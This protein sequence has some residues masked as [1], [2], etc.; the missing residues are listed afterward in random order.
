[1]RTAASVNEPETAIDQCRQQSASQPLFP[2][3]S[4]V[5]TRACHLLT[6]GEGKVRPGYGSVRPTSLKILC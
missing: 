3:V 2:S 4:H 5:S 1:M 6:Q